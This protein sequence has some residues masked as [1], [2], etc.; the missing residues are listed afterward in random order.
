MQRPVPYF[1]AV[2]QR[3][4]DAYL[5]RHGFV[6]SAMA[7]PTVVRYVRNGVYLDVSYWIEDA[8]QF[9]PMI[10]IGLLQTTSGDGRLIADGIGLW[11]AVKMQ[12]NQKVY[13]QLHFSNRRQM[14]TA[15]VRL[16]DDIIERCRA[17]HRSRRPMMNEL[18]IPRASVH[19]GHPRLSV[20]IRVPFILDKH[21]P[22]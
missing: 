15:L 4:L 1:E 14:E 22:T 9:V 16:R 21:A 11:Y 7:T 10:G 12:D 17:F 20:A 19:V 18:R 5:I 13:P 8:P 6:R 3:V 2:C